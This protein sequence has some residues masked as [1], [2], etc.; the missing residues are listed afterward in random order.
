M[1]EFSYLSRIISPSLYA[2]FLAV[3][4]FP[5]FI[6]WQKKHSLGQSI[7]KEGPN[8]HLHKEKTPSMGGVVVLISLVFALII[9]GFKSNLSFFFLPLA[10]FFLL[11]F[12][13][14]YFKTFGDKP[15]G[16]K[17]R[18][19][20]LVQLLLGGFIL[21]AGEG[22]LPPEV[23]IPFTGEIFYFSRWSFFLYGM[24]VLVGSANAFNLTDGLDGLA[25]GCGALTFGFW[26]AVFA[27]QGKGEL[28]MLSFAVV[29]ALLA[30]LFFNAWPARIFLGDTGS[31]P[32]GA[33]M[34]VMALLSGQ[35]LLL[36]LAGI[37]FFLDT[38][39]VILQVFCYRVFKRRI[40]LMSPVH[41]HFE[42]LG[43]KESEITSRFWVIQGVGV[44]IAILG[45]TG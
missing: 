45:A 36:L 20:F 26:G 29:G 14:D 32:L 37:I 28:A 40:F 16:L 43:K 7:K 1:M 39:S 30:F 31:L 5:F 33:L 3:I 6:S 34:G 13:D 44:I 8:L 17:A 42:L 23:E 12:L 24:L 18:Y 38:L 2:F 11:G 4:F 15:W 27:L 25:G 21:W 10:G 41:H 22:I 35:S 9:G 19:K